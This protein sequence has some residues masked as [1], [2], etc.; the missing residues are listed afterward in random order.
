MLLRRN[1]YWIRRE[2]GNC[3]DNHILKTKKTIDAL[4]CPPKHNQKE[5]CYLSILNKLSNKLAIHWNKETSLP[6][7]QGGEQGWPQL[8]A[9]LHERAAEIGSA[10]L[11]TDKP[12]Y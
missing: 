11:S 7:I 4:Y 3:S 9:D 2:S 12:T 10:Y 1:E 5:E 8:M 6:K